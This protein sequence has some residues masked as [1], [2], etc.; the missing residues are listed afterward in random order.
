MATPDYY[1]QNFFQ[2]E[3]LVQ[4]LLPLFVYVK[5]GYIIIWKGFVISYLSLDIIK[6]Y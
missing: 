5:D 4:S 2:W 3:I 1:K 6:D